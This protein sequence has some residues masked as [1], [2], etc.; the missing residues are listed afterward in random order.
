MTILSSLWSHVVFFP[1]PFSY[2][3]FELCKPTNIFARLSL[4]LLSYCNFVYMT[5]H[6]ITTLSSPQIIHKSPANGATYSLLCG[7][8]ALSLV[9]LIFALIAPL[10]SS[11]VSLLLPYLLKCPLV[12]L[13]L[14]SALFYHLKFKCLSHWRY[15]HSL[16]GTSPN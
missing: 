1:L 7:H 5:L 14:Y 3:S 13:T 10:N 11:V 16:P 6:R 4:L 12:R 15:H 8:F 2:K 9:C